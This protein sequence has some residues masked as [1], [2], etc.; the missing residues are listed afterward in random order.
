MNPKE[1]PVSRVSLWAD[2]LKR[3]I[4]RFP[5]LSRLLVT[6]H[7]VIAL[8]IFLW[9]WSN[10]GGYHNGIQW[11]V[12]SY[13]DY[14]VFIPLDY[15]PEGRSWLNPALMPDMVLNCLL[16]GYALVFGSLWWAGIGRVV[17]RSF[18]KVVAFKNKHAA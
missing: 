10:L 15:L 7:A 11:G 12:I 13:L 18:E 8:V 5:L 4:G 14:P 1:P 17:Q 2:R 6:I 9:V 16:F 3:F